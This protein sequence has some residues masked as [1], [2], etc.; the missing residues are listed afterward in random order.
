MSCRSSHISWFEQSARQD[1]AKH[2]APRVWIPRHPSPSPLAVRTSFS[3]END[4]RPGSPLPPPREP[5][6]VSP[7]WDSSLGPSHRQANRH[8]ESDRLPNQSDSGHRQIAMDEGP[9]RHRQAHPTDRNRERFNEDTR[10]VSPVAVGLESRLSERYDDRYAEAPYRPLPP[11][12]SSRRDHDSFHPDQHRQARQTHPDHRGQSH[13]FNVER[14]NSDWHDPSR[15]DPGPMPDADSHPERVRMYEFPA[16]TQEAAPP[17]ASKP[18]RVRRLGPNIQPAKEVIQMEPG[19]DDML[20][21][22][23]HHAP[24]RQGDQL[25]RSSY[26]RPNNLRRGGSLLDRLSLDNSTAVVSERLASA[27]L[28]DRVSI[29]SKRDHDELISGGE[30]APMD[31]PEDGG[32]SRRSRRRSGKSRRGKAR[33]GVS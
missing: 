18:P 30:E 9:H 31:A 8:H 15:G 29:P 17:R 33:N 19:A 12:S 7:V 27:S 22:G 3:G 20:A 11:A 14:S 24:E 6:V 32:D 23:G 1:Q 21:G 26:D 2:A 5:S 10:H 16:P 28:R 25:Q 4:Y 13:S